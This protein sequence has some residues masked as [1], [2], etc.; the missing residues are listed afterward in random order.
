[1]CARFT[2]AVPDLASLGRMLAAEVDPA[3][4]ALYRPRYNVA[5]SD[6]HLVLRERAGRRELIPAVW[7]L[8]NRW[9][10]E[11]KGAAGHVNARSEG[12]RSKPAFREAFARRRCVVPADGFYEWTGPKGARRPIWFSPAAGGL[13]HLAGL[14]ESW[15]D[16]ADG[17]LHP[18]FTILTTAAND[19]VAP[20]HDRMPAI[21]APEDLGAWLAAEH[22]D[23]AWAEALLRPAPPG[24]L[25]ARP[26]SP[27]V[28][29][30]AHDD[31]SLLRAEPSEAQG[32]LSL[33]EAKPRG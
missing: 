5:P 19:A 26:V 22:G 29:S 8:V 31:A 30:V 20:I 10:K 3:L 28:N 33:F 2:L 15:R 12:V 25:S 32:T 13:L 4:T 17:E 18:T 24:V 27:R 23:G 9:S 11:P 1:M 14:Y 6:V 21:L 7:G 16:P